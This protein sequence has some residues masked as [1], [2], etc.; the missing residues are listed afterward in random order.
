MNKYHFCTGI[1]SIEKRINL[2][3]I[4]SIMKGNTTEKIYVINQYERVKIVLM[5][6]WKK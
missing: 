6:H 3:I 1:V 2:K 4:K 5:V